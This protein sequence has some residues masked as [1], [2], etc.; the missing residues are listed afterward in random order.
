MKWWYKPKAPMLVL[1]HI[2]PDGSMS[3]FFMK[4]I[5]IPHGQVPHPHH[6]PS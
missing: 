6:R 5:P 2:Y 1:D 4:N 3:G